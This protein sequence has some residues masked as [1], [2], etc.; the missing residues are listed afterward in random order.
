MAEDHSARCSHPMIQILRVEIYGC[1]NS[2][3]NAR[4]TAVHAACC[5]AITPPSKAMPPDNATCFS[6]II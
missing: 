1:M 2:A 3:E 4:P 6:H 5:D